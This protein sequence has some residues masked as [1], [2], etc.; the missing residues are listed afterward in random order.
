[1]VL[2]PE[3][4]GLVAN[5]IGFEEEGQAVREAKG[6][7]P[8]GQACSVRQGLGLAVHEHLIQGELGHGA[9][10][11]LQGRI[12]DHRPGEAPRPDAALGIHHGSAAVEFGTRQS[13]FHP[14]G[15]NPNAPILEAHPRD[16][17]V[18]EGVEA[19]LLI[20]SHLVHRIVRQGGRGRRGKDLPLRIR[21]EGCHQQS[22]PSV[23]ATSQGLPSRVTS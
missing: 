7:I 11:Q 10:G 4:L 12:K 16:A 21:R 9:L 22:A 8:P 19:A 14:E 5:P 6:A 23:P 18:G 3:Q 20:G 15:L 1:M 2:Q 13:V 17:L